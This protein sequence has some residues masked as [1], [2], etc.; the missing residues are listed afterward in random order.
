MLVVAAAVAVVVLL[1]LV[2]VRCAAVVCC[3]AA[4]AWL[5]LLLV[6]LPAVA[7]AFWLLLLLAG[8]P[9]LL[10]LL[11]VLCLLLWSSPLPPAVHEYEASHTVT[12][13]IASILLLISK[14]HQREFCVRPASRATFMMA[15]YS[16]LAGGLERDAA[17]QRVQTGQAGSPVCGGASQALGRL[18]PGLAVGRLENFD[19]HPAHQESHVRRADTL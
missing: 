10:L 3:A 1:L 14:A 17:A 15:G 19:A 13:A 5:L 2:L 18:G 8:A 12:E 6:R 11:C 16:A 4:A 7:A 9:A